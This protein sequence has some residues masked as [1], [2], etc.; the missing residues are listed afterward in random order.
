VDDQLQQLIDF[1]L[2]FTFRHRCL[3]STKTKAKTRASSG[4]ALFLPFIASKRY[5][6]QPRTFLGLQITHGM[7]EPHRGCLNFTVQVAGK[8]DVGC[9]RSNNE[10]F[11]GY[12]AAAGVFVVCDG[13]GGQAAGEVASQIGVHVVLDYFRGA[14]EKG[15]YAVFGRVFAGVS[16]CAN[17]LGSAIQMANRSILDAA[18]EDPA[19]AGMSSTIVAGLVKGAD[20]SIAHVGDSRIY[21]LRGDTI[22]QLTTD[23]SLVMEQVRLGM[24]SVEDA[25]R[26]AAQNLIVRALGAE[27]EVEPDLADL[28]PE[29]GDILLFTSDGLTRHVGDSQIVSIVRQASSLD[30]ACEALIQ[31]AKDGGGSDNITCLLVRLVEQTWYRKLIS[32]NGRE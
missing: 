1:G 3:L 24:I 11:F 19:C 2:K 18:S 14:A 31:T 26:S 17:A 8:T 12:D 23:H 25:E 7:L 21:L 28:A 30:E 22:Q 9:V 13:V 32:G 15:E 29:P 27:N 16:P 20:V 5:L 10:D 6:G 4:T